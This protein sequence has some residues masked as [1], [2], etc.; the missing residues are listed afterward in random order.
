[1]S[2]HTNNNLAPDAGGTKLLVLVDTQ[3]PGTA[4]RD[5]GSRLLESTSNAPISALLS[6]ELLDVTLSIT[7]EACTVNITPYGMLRG[8]IEI[9]WSGNNQPVILLQDEVRAARAEEL[10]YL[11]CMLDLIR[12]AER[13]QTFRSRRISHPELHEAFQERW[14]IIDE[15]LQQ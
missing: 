10:C 3:E 15:V 4:E 5:Y 7:L 8:T 9:D 11:L 12:E 1:M 13:S 2:L 6:F 14:E